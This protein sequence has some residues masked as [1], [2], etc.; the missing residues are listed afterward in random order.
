MQ[1]EL[2]AKLAEITTAIAEL[3]T[4][5]ELQ[6]SYY[7]GRYNTLRDMKKWLEGMIVNFCE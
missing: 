2:K 5:T 4:N 3:E 7:F 1:N 6:T